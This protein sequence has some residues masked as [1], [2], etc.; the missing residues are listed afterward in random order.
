MEK[1]IKI[2]LNLN[3]KTIYENNK[4]T[5]RYIRNNFFLRAL[6]KKKKPPVFYIIFY[7]TL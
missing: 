7:L 5:L 4:I 1:S 3:P 6:L 2:D